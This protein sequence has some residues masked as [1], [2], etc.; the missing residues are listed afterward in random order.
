[1]N[2]VGADDPDQGRG[3]TDEDNKLSEEE[4]T[5]ALLRRAASES[6]QLVH[7][8]SKRVLRYTVNA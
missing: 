2:V 8:I 6:V 1:M 4:A 3:A 7:V 5:K